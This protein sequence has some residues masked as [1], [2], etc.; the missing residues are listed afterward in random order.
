MGIQVI[1]GAT[2]DL[3][4]VDPNQKAARVSLRPTDV[5]ALGA[6]ALAMDNGTTVFT[7][8]AQTAVEFFQFRWR[9]ATRLCILRSIKI[10]M[11]AVV[12]FA[13]GKLA[14]TGTV[15]RSFTAV[16]SGTG[17]AT[18]TLT[19]NNNKKR[20]SHGSTLVNSADVV[21]AGTAF[22]SAGTKTFDANAFANLS[23]AAPSTVGPILTNQV[24]WQRDSGDEWPFVFV[25][26]EGFALRLWAP[27][28]GTY[29]IGVDIEW[30]EVTAY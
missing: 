29:F 15:A 20:T 6:Y 8:G 26:D 27:A 23:I 13:A 19:G 7:A 14:I 25:A 12:A 21:M 30:A 11:G 24:L 3:L 18:P 1:S 9:D 16:G 2:T 4:T 5:G 28:T 17:S 10:D 22:L